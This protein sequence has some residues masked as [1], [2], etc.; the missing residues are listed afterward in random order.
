VI[1]RGHIVASSILG[2]GATTL[3]IVSAIL[4]LT[5]TVWL[6]FSLIIVYAVYVYLLAGA[7]LNT[8]DERRGRG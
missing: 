6:G 4:G 5:W 7:I 8:I 1:Y 2:V 3:M